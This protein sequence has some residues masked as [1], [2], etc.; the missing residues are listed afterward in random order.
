[1][2]V[3]GCLLIG[4]LSQTAR[5]PGRFTSDGVLFLFVGMLGAFTTFS[6]FEKE[7]VDL[8]QSRRAAAALLN[9]GTQVMAGLAAVAGGYELGRLLQR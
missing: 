7:T 3:I 1:V 9:V 6:T 8:L 4:V 2:N 5:T